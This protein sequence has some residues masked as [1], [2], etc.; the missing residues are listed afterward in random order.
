M[1]TLVNYVPR[2]K[3]LGVSC[4]VPEFQTYQDVPLEVPV[5]ESDGSVV[6]TDVVLKQVPVEQVMSKYRVKDFALA[7]LL[8]SGVPL[9]VVNINHSSAFELD[10]LQKICRDVDAAEKL[11]DNIEA[12]KKEKESWFNLDNVP[13]DPNSSNHVNE[14][15]EN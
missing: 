1:G 12:Q 7:A 4:A 15:L 9:K 8:D 13:F 10:E 2:H 6:R 14:A 3:R 11:V 5:I